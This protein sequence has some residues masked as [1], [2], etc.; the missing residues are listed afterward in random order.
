MNELKVGLLALA[1]IISLAVVSLKITA[2]QS[3]FGSHR[4]YTAELD[5]AT[6]VYPKTTIKVAG[7]NSGKVKKVEL[8]DGKALITFEVLDTIKVTKGTELHVKSLGFLGDIYLD[9]KLGPANLKALNEGSKIV[10]IQ[11]GGLAN[12]ANQATE[13][14]GEIKGIL[15]LIKES[16]Q[17][18]EKENKLAKILNNLEQISQDSKEIVAGFKGYTDGNSDKLS[19]IVDNIKALTEQIAYET[20]RNSDGSLM[21]QVKNVNPI[22]ADA[23]QV[24]ND[25]K[26]IINDVK[27]G[28]GVAGKLLRD[29]QMGEKVDQTISN[30]NQIFASFNRFKTDISFFTGANNTDYRGEKIIHSE[31]NLD[32]GTSP[33][34]MF[35]FGVVDTKLGPAVYSDTDTT[36]NGGTTSNKVVTDNNAVKFNF[37]IGRRFQDFRVRAGI[38]QST[39]GIGLDYMMLERGM[40]FSLDTFNFDNDD[41]PF[42]RLTSEFRLWK[43]FYTRLTAENMA[44]KDGEKSGTISAGVRFNDNDVATLLGLLSR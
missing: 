34:K 22:L 38:F 18:D 36:N 13:M 24:M 10:A 7:I 17:T 39:A 16:L 28:R 41:A 33:E 15:V 40:M 29:D 8:I 11:A 23:K 1:A 37:Q 9:L 3:G 19:S 43:I 5:D 12:A 21:S 42:V 26:E 44:A 31:L 2:N 32:L 14:I 6:G 20:D 35:R 4:E 27:Q 25:I 30:V